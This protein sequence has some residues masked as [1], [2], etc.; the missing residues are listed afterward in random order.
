[1]SRA[2]LARRLLQAFSAFMLRT[3]NV[4]TS[5]VNDFAQT[6]PS[7][8]EP[9]TLSA[10]DVEYALPRACLTAQV[11]FIISKIYSFSF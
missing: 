8:T 7:I 6:T 4:L 5:N 10:R 2:W 3:A 11:F 9:S 1:M